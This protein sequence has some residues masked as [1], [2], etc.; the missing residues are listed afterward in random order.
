LRM[1]AIVTPENKRLMSAR[2]VK[3]AGC[4]ML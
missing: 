4:R 3:A 1:A 2:A